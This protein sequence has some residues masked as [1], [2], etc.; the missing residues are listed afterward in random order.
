MFY[1]VYDKRFGSLVRAEDKRTRPTDPRWEKL[2]FIERLD[3]PMKLVEVEKDIP[4]DA[5][6]VWFAL[7]DPQPFWVMKQ[8]DMWYRRN[9]F[10]HVIN[11]PLKTY[12]T[13][14][15][16]FYFLNSN[17]VRAPY[18]TQG[19]SLFNKTEFHSYGP[20]F[21]CEYVNTIGQNPTDST[22]IPDSSKHHKVWRLVYS[23]G[24]IG[25]QC[26]RLEGAQ[27]WVGTGCAD[28]VKEMRPTPPKYKEIAE[29]VAKVSGLE[30]FQIEIIPSPWV[31]PVVC[32]V[33][34]HSFDVMEGL[35]NNRFL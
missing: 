2:R 15:L 7:P 13:K 29:R 19:K 5:K 33:N 17:G 31:G 26:A 11:H 9:K 12:R 32:D 24:K 28:Y 20:E 6:V 8:Y 14:Q 3:V 21:A 16:W 22:D 27:F 23:V 1:V 34:P 10:V 30:Y 4:K 35:L 18:P 25:E